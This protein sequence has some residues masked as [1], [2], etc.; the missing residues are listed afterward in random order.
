MMRSCHLLNSSKLCKVSLE[1]S[2][3][4]YTREI[5]I[6]KIL[7]DTYIPSNVLMVE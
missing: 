3:C 2:V 4:E 1:V 5:V 7:Y 6:L